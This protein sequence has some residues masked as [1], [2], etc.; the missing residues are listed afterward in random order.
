MEDISTTPEKNSEKD[1]DAENLDESLLDGSLAEGNKKGE[2]TQD[3]PQVTSTDEA[4][5]NEQKKDED[6]D[7]PGKEK[8]HDPI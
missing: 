3:K 1:K 4:K 5:P 2:E 7:F 6:K 8:T